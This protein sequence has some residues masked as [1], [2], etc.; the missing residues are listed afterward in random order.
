MAS[1]EAVAKACVALH[2]LYGPD[3]FPA[4]DATGLGVW[5]WHLED[6]SDEQLLQAVK[7]WED[8]WPPSAPALRRA[9]RG[10]EPERTYSAPYHRPFELDE[11]ERTPPPDAIRELAQSLRA[12]NR[13]LNP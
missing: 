9:A 2:V 8:D 5:A 4:L 10:V 1:R 3:R 6:V 11:G 7:D 13:E 12:R